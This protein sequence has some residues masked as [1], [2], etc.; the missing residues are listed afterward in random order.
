MVIIKSLATAMA[1]S[2][3]ILAVMAAPASAA[4][5]TVNQKNL[6]FTPGTVTINVGDTVTFTNHD[7]FFHDVTIINPDGTKSDK[8]LKNQ[9]QDIKVTF[10]SAG[11]YGVMCRLHPMMKATVIVKQP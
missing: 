9:G 10:T 5:V 3:S 6:Q 11:T 1:A 7:P 8:G 4:D 2:I